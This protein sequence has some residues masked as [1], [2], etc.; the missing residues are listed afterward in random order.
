MTTNAK[1]VTR[2]IMKDKLLDRELD[3]LPTKVN[4]DDVRDL[5][6]RYSPRRRRSAPF[7]YIIGMID[8]LARYSAPFVGLV[9]GANYAAAKALFPLMGKEKHWGD[10]LRIYLGEDLG[11]KMAD[12]GKAFEVTG[13][14]IAA[15]PKIFAWAL[16]G[17]V[18]GVA[19][20]Y[21]AKWILIFGVFSRRRLK[22]RRKVSELLA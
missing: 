19:A 8:F 6:R 1:R 16:Y 12:M 17:A 20:Y 11:Q 2:S 3:F 21:V 15:T 18:I 14:M 9:A 5:A 13:T 7:R 10:S 22:L 4:R